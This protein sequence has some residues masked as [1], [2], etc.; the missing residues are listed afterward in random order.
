[1]HDS[2]LFDPW[3]TE[4]IRNAWKSDRLSDNAVAFAF[5]RLDN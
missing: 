1:M 4:L 5:H 2:I 3:P